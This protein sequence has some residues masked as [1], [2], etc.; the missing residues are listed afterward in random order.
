[1]HQPSLN[2]LTIGDRIMVRPRWGYDPAIEVT[3]TGMEYAG[4][5][6]MDVIDYTNEYGEPKWAYIDAV[7]CI[8]ARAAA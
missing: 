4:K 1:M 3:L 7:D 5:N 6:G 2:D 8:V